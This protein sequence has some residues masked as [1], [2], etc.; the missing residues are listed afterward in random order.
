MK[1]VLTIVFSLVIGATYGQSSQ[2]N[3]GI[4]IKKIVNYQSRSFVIPDIINDST[5]EKFIE[6]EYLYSQEVLVG[7]RRLYFRNN[8]N[9]E[10]EY[11]SIKYLSRDSVVVS[12]TSKGRTN[13]FNL[14]LPDFL[15][16]RNKI[17]EGEMRF[18]SDFHKIL[19]VSNEV[20]NQIEFYKKKYYG[21]G[22]EDT[23]ALHYNFDSI[24]KL[25][26]IIESRLNPD[27]TSWYRYDFGDKKLTISS[28]SGENWHTSTEYF[29]NSKG[30][31][32]MKGQES[33]TNASIT[34]Y[35]Y[36][37]GKGNAGAFI[38]TI[39]DVIYYTPLIK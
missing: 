36:E 23:V 34:V 32:T 19:V 15:D 18:Y 35:E 9:L 25:N 31:L 16:L 27:I 8:K 2:S 39:Y 14:K 38:N 4:R 22:Y 3:S 24:Q 20:G 21:N 33:D 37:E 6:T 17:S 28:G 5:A 10:S 26:E 13:K 30:L 1:R 7:I 12:R 11:D 29:F